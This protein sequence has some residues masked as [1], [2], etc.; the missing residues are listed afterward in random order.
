[1]YSLLF[2]EL[3]YEE[4]NKTWATAELSFMSYNAFRATNALQY[5]NTYRPLWKLIQSMNFM[6]ENYLAARDYM[7]SLMV[8]KYPVYSQ[9]HV[10]RHKEQ[11]EEDYKKQEELMK[12]LNK[13]PSIEN[14]NG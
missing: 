2:V 4:V 7:Y 12:K 14:S 11:F 5:Y 13:V 10:P 6:D 1:M 8:S 3:S 9:V